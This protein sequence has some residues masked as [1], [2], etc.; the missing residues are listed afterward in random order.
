MHRK[1]KYGKMEEIGM[2]KRNHLAALAIARTIKRQAF[3][4]AVL[5][6]AALALAFPEWFI[7]WGEVKLIALVVPAI[8]VKYQSLT[9]RS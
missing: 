7:Q 1:G 3:G 2:K 9:S 5:V 4:V 8:Q 6:S